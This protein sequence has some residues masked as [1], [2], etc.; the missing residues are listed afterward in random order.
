MQVKVGAP[1]A[2]VQPQPLENVLLS[3]V[4]SPACIVCDF[5]C[6]SSQ[7]TRKQGRVS[8]GIAS[9]AALGSLVSKKL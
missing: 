4:I 3:S 1:L 8:Q 9:T 2:T 7:R 6:V 5:L